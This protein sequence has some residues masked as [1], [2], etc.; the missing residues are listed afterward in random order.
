MTQAESNKLKATI[1]ELEREYAEI[2]RTAATQKRE[3]DATLTHVK[4]ELTMVAENYHNASAALKI[5]RQE[6]EQYQSA[7]AKLKSLL[8]EVL[9][10]FDGQAPAYIENIRI[11]LK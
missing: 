10:A 3:A 5:A 9:E 2:T 1:F 6:V 11:V 4:S 8:T 7:N